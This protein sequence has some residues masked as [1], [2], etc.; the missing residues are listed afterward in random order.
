L[1]T[2]ASGSGTVVDVVDVVDVVVDVDGDGGDVVVAGMVV[3][4]VVAVG[5]A[6][7]GGSVADGAVLPWSDVGTATLA[8][9][10]NSPAG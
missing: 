1:A 7:I 9:T 8:S 2:S 10:P 5:A 4:I 6:V 3:G